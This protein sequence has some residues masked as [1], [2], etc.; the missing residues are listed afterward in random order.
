MKG[1][2]KFYGQ[3]MTEDNEKWKIAI[4]RQNELY[5]KTDDVRNDFNRDYNRI[6]YSTAYRRLKHK[7]QVFYGTNNDHVCTRIEHVHHVGAISYTIC[8]ALGLNQDL[9]TAIAIGHDIGHAPF[10]HEGEK[11]INSLSKKYLSSNFWHERNSLNLADNIETLTSKDGNRYNLNL[12]Y[13]VRDGLISHCGEVD[14]NGLKPRDETINLNEIEFPN[15]YQPHTWEACVVKIADKIAYLGR[16]IEDA[17]RLKILNKTQ[18]DELKESISEQLDEIVE[19]VN[20]ASLINAFVLDLCKTSDIEKGIALSEP[21]F[22]LMQ[23]IKEYNCKHIYK[24]KRIKCYNPFVELV[25]KTIF[26]ILTDS[27]AIK[28]KPDFN[29]ISEFNQSLAKSFKKWLIKLSDID[30]CEKKKLKYNNPVVYSIS[31]RSDYFNAVLTYISLMTD[32]YAI[33]K[34][35]EIIEF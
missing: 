2:L 11:I 6:L 32:N 4:E 31:N 35:N 30:E 22:K 16:D 29:Y 23:T 17:L 27:Y 19:E 25:I 24:H 33:E 26:S 3:A 14:E 28:N 7:T 1:K 12:T 20:T 10:G 21:Y 9:A 34:F 5:K 15:Q 18:I 8:S 13:A